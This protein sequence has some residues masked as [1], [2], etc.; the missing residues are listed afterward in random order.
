M[1]DSK[2]AKKIRVELNKAALA[3]LMGNPIFEKEIE[4]QTKK[5][6]DAANMQHVVMERPV[7]TSMMAVTV[8]DVLNAIAEVAGK[9]ALTEAV[10]CTAI[11]EAGYMEWRS[12][13]GP[14]HKQHEQERNRVVI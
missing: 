8:R 9:E 2:T 3:E 13:M 6:T 14:K 7:I 11:T 1:S 12:I 4:E 10:I 5:I